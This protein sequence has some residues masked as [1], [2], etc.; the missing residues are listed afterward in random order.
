VSIALS[1]SEKGS[2]EYQSSSQSRGRRTFRKTNSIYGDGN[3]E[4]LR[5]VWKAEK[6]MRGIFKS[7]KLY[8][9]PIIKDAD[10]NIKQIG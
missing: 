4:N 1:S 3:I 5:E 7:C 8:E 6:E 9:I 2:K 10:G